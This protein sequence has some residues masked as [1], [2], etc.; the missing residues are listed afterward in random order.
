MMTCGWMISFSILRSTLHGHTASF[1]SPNLDV[2]APHCEHS[3]VITSLLPAVPGLIV[4][5]TIGRDAWHSVQCTN[6]SK[7]VLIV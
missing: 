2:V 3:Y 1:Y 5:I 6:A 7:K 4:L